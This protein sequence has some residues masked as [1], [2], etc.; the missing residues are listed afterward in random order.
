M[1]SNFYIENLTLE[2]YSLPISFNTY[3][4][5]VFVC[6]VY[7]KIEYHSPTDFN[8]RNSFSFGS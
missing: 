8:D 3:Y 1:F 5:S 7:P 4:A 2:Q 6:C